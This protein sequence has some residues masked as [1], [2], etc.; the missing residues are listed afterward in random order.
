MTA[1]PD[2]KWGIS[3]L[4]CHELDLT[5][6]CKLAATHRVRH[7]EIRSLAS[8]LNLP[9]Y[10][11]ANYP[12]G[13]GSVQQI[14]D[15]YQQS[16]VALNSGFSLINADDKARQGLLEFG[17]WANLLNV[18]FVRVFG[19][20]SMGT[21]LSESDLKNAVDNLQWWK[22]Q[23][24]QNEW[25]THI[26]LE[27]HDGFS[28]GKRCRQLE[29]AFGGQVDII[30][31]THHTWKAGQESPQQTWDQIGSRIRHVH[32]K[33]S[34][35]VP[36]DRHPY[37]YVLPGKGEFPFAEACGVLYE[38]NYQGVVSLEWER[39]WH[40]YLPDLQAA[41]VGLDESG[42]RWRGPY[43]PVGHVMPEVDAAVLQGA[44]YS[45]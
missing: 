2:I 23:R 28:S 44:N 43:R 11:D 22:R 13:P 29:D 18:P 31:D 27:T 34:I 26:A 42:W 24:E 35:S 36:S 37:S 14:L 38:N 41:L 20:G 17:R 45:T 25:R 12:S 8:C 19:G 10:L 16:I 33:D 6:A 4:G 32:V 15:E 9:E 3:T 7:L 5:A 1:P 40:P 21:P 30:W 39:K